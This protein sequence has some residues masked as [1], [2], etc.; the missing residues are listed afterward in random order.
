MSFYYLIFVFVSSKVGGF[1]PERGCPGSYVIDLFFLCSEF[2]TR[3][4]RQLDVCPDELA[5]AVKTVVGEL[6]Q[7]NLHLEVA[8]SNPRIWAYLAEQEKLQSADGDEATKLLTNFRSWDESTGA[9]LEKVKNKVSG[10][11]V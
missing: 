10:V 9:K 8:D 1:F 7:R 2:N 5:S 3:L 11:N 4:V 6:K